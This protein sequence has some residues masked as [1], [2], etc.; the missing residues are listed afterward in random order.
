MCQ[1]GVIPATFSEKVVK[2][3]AGITPHCRC[4]YVIY[5]ACELV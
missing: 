1:C 3:V 2:K 5:L 4:V